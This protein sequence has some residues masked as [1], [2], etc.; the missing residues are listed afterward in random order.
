MRWFSVVVALLAVAPITACRKHRGVSVRTP[1]GLDA[2]A[3]Q[4][5]RAVAR[6]AYA[7]A[8]QGFDAKMLAAMPVEQ[9]EAAW[10]SLV[11]RAGPFQKVAAYRHEDRD[12]YRTVIVTTKHAKLPIDIRVVFDKTEKIAGLW[13]APATPDWRPPPYV[14][15]QSFT[16]TEVSVRELPGTLSV[17][18]A[19]GPFR[20]AVL[21]HGSGPNDRDETLGASKPFRD[22]AQGLASRGI[23]V[24]RYD[25]RSKYAPQT[26]KGAFDQDDEVSFDARAAV[27][28]L[29]A[30]SDID[31]KHIVI[32][33][34]SQGGS[35]APRIARG[36]PSIAAIAI[37]AGDTRPFEKLVLDQHRYL[38]SVQGADEV[39]RN[40]RLERL[41]DEFR[42]VRSDGPDDE[43]LRVMGAPA[44]RR[45][46]RD[47]LDHSGATIAKELSI[48]MFIAQGARDYQVTM[49][50]FTGW[51]NALGS[52][53]DVTFRV[54]PTL[55]H[56]FIAGEGPSTPEEYSWPGHVDRAVVE[57][58]AQWL[59]ALH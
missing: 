51:K 19:G 54:Y 10:R 46:W 34:H 20:A 48:P 7:D 59:K 28:V 57:D 12:E 37:L 1:R 43:M 25:K 38:L 13:F 6:G 39:T 23:A 9:L 30:R 49:E 14:A 26:L 21:I 33:G 17:P 52:R 8:R 53:T 16:E 50:D 2:R 44:P 36:T 41:R 11:E 27:A 3:D 29:A 4:F 40:H 42:R 45:Y 35:M 24:L 55:N 32:I 31:A 22:L 18:R 58:L 15:T 5:V 56:A 47:L